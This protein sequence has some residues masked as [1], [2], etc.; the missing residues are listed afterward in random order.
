M[1]T[2]SVLLIISFLILMTKKASAKT[3]S[4]ITVKRVDS[5][6]LNSILIAANR[7]GVPDIRIRA[8]IAVE[9][10]GYPKV[11]G[12][13][14]ERGLMQ[15]LPG[16]LSDVNRTYRFGFTFDDMFDAEKNILTGTAYLAILIK[17]SKG[18]IDLAT[19]AYNVG[20]RNAI[21]GPGWGKAYLDKVKAFEVQFMNTKIT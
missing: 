11:P 6:Y 21:K 20:Y 2:I 9:S 13:K 4:A 14:G 16:A 19:R 18:D 1:T 17:Q 15:I 3:A 12:S 10:A 8:M 7:F 5:N